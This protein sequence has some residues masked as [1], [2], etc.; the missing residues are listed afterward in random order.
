MAEANRF[1]WPL[2][3]YYEDTDAGGVVYHAGYL[4]FMERARTEWLRALDCEQGVLRSDHD[5]LLAVRSV[6]IDFLQP[7][8]FDDRLQVVTV[9]HRLGRASIVFDQRI[10][11]DEEGE[12]L[13]HAMVKVACLS[14]SGFRPAPIPAWLLGR[15][16]PLESTT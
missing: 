15:F 5:R 11:R 8:R 14:A 9:I 12:P 7:A 1:V 3:V 13:C 16:P 10:F 4:R 2:R 6:Q